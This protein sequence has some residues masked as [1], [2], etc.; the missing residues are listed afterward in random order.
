[1]KTEWGGGGDVDVNLTLITKVKLC[2]QVSSVILNGHQDVDATS[3]KMDV[4]AVNIVY[5]F[6]KGFLLKQGMET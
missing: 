5:S 4:D 1:M 3:V 2:R 6:P